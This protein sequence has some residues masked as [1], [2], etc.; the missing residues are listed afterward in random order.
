MSSFACVS[1][2]CSWV[3]TELYIDSVENHEFPLST[4]L[5]TDSV[6]NHEFPLS[7][8]LYI[9]SVENHEFPLSTELYST[10]VESHE[11]FLNLLSCTLSRLLSTSKNNTTTSSSNSSLFSKLQSSSLLLH[12]FLPRTP[13]LSLLYTLSPHPLMAGQSIGN[14]LYLIL[15][16]LVYN[17]RYTHIYLTLLPK[18]LALSLLSLFLCILIIWCFDK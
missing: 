1:A 13:G 18:P 10:S 7:T 16:L 4:E 3:S 8:E 2:V 9:D 17:M 5:Y 15:G 11:I 12:L 14:H 6:E